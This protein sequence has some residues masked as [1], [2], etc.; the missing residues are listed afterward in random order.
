MKSATAPG[1]AT[2]PTSASHRLRLSTTSSPASRRAAP[3][4]S[5]GGGGLGGLGLVTA[6]YLAEHGAGRLV[7]R[8]RHIPPAPAHAQLDALRRQGCDVQVVLGDI[9]DPAVVAQA[10]TTTATAGSPTSR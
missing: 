3:T 10:I 9:A 1:N 8:G 7:L 6:A 2:S 5:A 4:W